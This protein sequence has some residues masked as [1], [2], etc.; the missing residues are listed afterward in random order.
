MLA[1][2]LMG[3]VLVLLRRDHAELRGALGVLV[4]ADASDHELGDALEAV[5]LGLLS[6][7]SGE[8]WLIDAVLDEVHPS[9]I[10]YLLC[11][12]V[13]AAHFAQEAAL[14]ALEQARRGDQTFRERAAHLADLI[15]DHDKHEARCVI[16]ALR[17]YLSRELYGE[18]CRSYSI[19]RLRALGTIPLTLGTPGCRS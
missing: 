16:P 4:A 2:V 15:Q 19:G 12:Q 14:A 13:L 9:A 6:H 3:D 11:S 8:G 18:L 17:D 1:A 7:T 10:V 5:R